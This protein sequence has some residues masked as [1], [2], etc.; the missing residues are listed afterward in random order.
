MKIF[1]RK[2][3][4][5][6]WFGAELMLMGG[7]LFALKYVI[8]LVPIALTGYG[9]Y[10]CFLRKSYVDGITF[11]T[12]GVLLW[13]VF[14]LFGPL[15]LIPWILGLGLMGAGGVLIFVPNKKKQLED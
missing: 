15:L 9:L 2:G 3:K 14:K 6:R 7:A 4:S 11:T 12:S 1:N 10:R 13:G 8:S 5:R